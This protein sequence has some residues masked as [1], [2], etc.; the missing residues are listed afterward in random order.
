MG[1]F[2]GNLLRSHSDGGNRLRLPRGEDCGW[3]P[4]RWLYRPDCKPSCR[5]LSDVALSGTSAIVEA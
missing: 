2:G 5:L 3:L 4:Y 1:T